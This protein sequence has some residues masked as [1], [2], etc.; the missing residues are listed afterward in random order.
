MV[1]TDVA[2]KIKSANAQYEGSAVVHVDKL[3]N[4]R[5]IAPTINKTATP[6]ALESKYTNRFDDYN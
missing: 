4:I 5:A 1:T 3:G 2:Q 6:E